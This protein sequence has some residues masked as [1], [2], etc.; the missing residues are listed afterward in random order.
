MAPPHLIT[1][2]LSLLFLFSSLQRQFYDYLNV[3]SQCASHTGQIRLSQ[4]DFG[5]SS[6]L[7]FRAQMCGI[8]QNTQQI[9]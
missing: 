9:S 2:H 1:H 6:C 8:S 3:D 4:E 5:N 7:F